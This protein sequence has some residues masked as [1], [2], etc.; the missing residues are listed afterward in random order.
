M[1]DEWRAGPLGD[2]HIEPA[3]TGRRNRDA[4]HIATL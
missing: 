3:T 1:E 4:P 2:K